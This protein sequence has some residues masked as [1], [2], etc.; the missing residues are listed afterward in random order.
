[1]SPM[2]NRWPS[3]TGFHLAVVHSFLFVFWGEGFVVVVVFSGGGGGGGGGGSPHHMKLATLDITVIG[4]VCMCVVY[5]KPPPNS[6]SHGQLVVQLLEIGS[7]STLSWSVVVGLYKLITCTT[8]FQKL[9]Q[10]T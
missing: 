7:T 10:P 8:H 9:G 4:N 5:T 3:N 6:K 1:M 2:C